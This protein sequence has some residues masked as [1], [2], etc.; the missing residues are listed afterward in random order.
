MSW[1][2][3]LVAPS[4]ACAWFTQ[5]LRKG[6]VRE[7]VQ[8]V[9]RRALLVSLLLM[10]KSPL[11]PRWNSKVLQSSAAARVLST[12]LKNPQWSSSPEDSFVIARYFPQSGITYYLFHWSSVI[13]RKYCDGKFTLPNS[14]SDDGR[15]TAVDAAVGVPCNVTENRNFDR[16]D[17]D[18]YYSEKAKR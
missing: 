17:F 10:H 13:V 18:D 8:R 15:I 9:H 12:I 1:I 4:V 16:S 2:F 14:S 5:G 11:I 6:L 3:R 7:R